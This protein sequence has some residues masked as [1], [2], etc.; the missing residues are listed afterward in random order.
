MR[1]PQLFSVKERPGRFISQGLIN[2]YRFL[3]SIT[4]EFQNKTAAEEKAV[5]LNVP[6]CLPQE[7]VK[8]LIPNTCG[9]AHRK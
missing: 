9:V 1:L 4:T 6:N 2:T 7:M 3:G 5:V 8:P